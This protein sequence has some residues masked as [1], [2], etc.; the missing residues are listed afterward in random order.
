MRCFLVL[1]LCI[2]A[3]RCEAATWYWCTPL[4][5][6]YPQ[7]QTCPIQWRPVEMADQPQP[8]Q[9]QTSGVSPIEAAFHAGLTERGAWET[10]DAALTGDYRAGA[11][12]WASHRSISNPG[13]CAN[14]IGVIPTPAWTA[15]CMASKTRLDPTDLKRKND[16]N[17]RRGWNSYS[18]AVA[19]V[20]PTAAP[21]S[22]LPPA[23]TPDPVATQ[24]MAEEQRRKEAAATEVADRLAK[25]EAE[26][27]AD[28]EAGYKVA[29]IPD[30]RLDYD[31]M[32]EDSHVIV[33]GFY[34]NL[35][36][37][38][39]L[40]QGGGGS[41]TV[42]I[43]SEELPREVRKDILDCNGC[44][45]TIW[46]HPGCTLTLFNQPSHAP[47]LIADKLRRGPYGSG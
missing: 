34:S 39:E 22:I 20:T 9:P 29:T 5:A 17:Y 23:A 16:P 11:D 41:N 1:L 3:W 28:A 7:V 2:A 36:Q 43:N 37:V 40:V 6:Y 10:W 14:P 8:S 13:T 33:T 47:C 24:E 42:Y 38:G 21:T 46:A 32:T 30:I 12:Y 44:Y 19:T 27:R 15:G 45:V 26:K 18:P 4:H 35:G 31:T 25:A